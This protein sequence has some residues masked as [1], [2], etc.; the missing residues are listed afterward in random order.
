MATRLVKKGD[1]LGARFDLAIIPVGSDPD[2]GTGALA[3]LDRTLGGAVARAVADGELTGKAGSAVTFH[4]PAGGAAR[5][6]VVGVGAGRTEDWQAAGAAAAAR[7]RAVRARAVSLLADGLGAPEVT[8]VV[9][10][11]WTGARRFD[12]FKGGTGDAPAPVDPDT[13]SVFGGAAK[14]AALKEAD[15][16]AAS[17]NSTRDLVETPGNHLTPRDLAAHAEALADGVPGLKVTVLNEGRLAKLGAGALL[18][19]AQG[20]AQPPR[21]IVMRWEPPAPADP[22]TVLGVV[23]KAVTF[24]SGG[25]SIKPSAGMEEMKTDM[26]GGAA[27]LESVALL[28]RLGVPVRA[29]AVVPSTENMPSSTAVKPGDV[30][31]AMNGKTIEVTNTD[32]EG[33][34]ILA[35]ALC[36][37]VGQG[38]TRIVDMAT[39]TGAVIVGLGEVYAG[40]LGNDPQWT[41]RVRAAADASGDL[42]WELPMHERYRPL[43]ESTVADMANSSS[44]RQAGPIYAAHF[45]AEF[46]GETPWCHLDIAG[47]ATPGGKASGYGVRLVLELARGLVVSA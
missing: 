36:Y 1:A 37:A 7:A 41:A 26:A 12:R 23:G 25:I 32:A 28:A 13:L 18:A 35:D 8:D 30:V 10:G 44:K 15:V 19:V 38:A 33:R 31:T 45:L 34:M 42:A 27:A 20:S 24:D 22:Q 40:L 4:L 43:I 47:T 6:L 21:M 9:E 46:V 16:V 11:F 17:V 5:V 14:A 39:L 2:P 29:M 3:G